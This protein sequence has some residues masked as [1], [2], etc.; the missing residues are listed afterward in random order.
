VTAG[1]SAGS[2]ALLRIRAEM[3]TTYKR[4][5]RGEMSW[6]D[7]ARATN[8]LGAIARFKAWPPRGVA[9]RIAAVEACLEE[10]GL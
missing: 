2:T 9:K 7:A 4:A 1:G 8:T 10:Q 5:V 3:V 6:Q